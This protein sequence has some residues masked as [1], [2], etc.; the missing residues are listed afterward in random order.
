[1]DRGPREQNLEGILTEKRTDDGF[2]GYDEIQ[3]APMHEFASGL[4]DTKA[5]QASDDCG[6]GIV[7]MV[8]GMPM[9]MPVFEHGPADAIA[10]PR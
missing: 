7:I 8:I 9:T 10:N 5:D 2:V 6:A 4:A 1:V 3:S